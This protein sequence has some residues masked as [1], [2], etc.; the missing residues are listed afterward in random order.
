MTKSAFEAYL[1]YVIFDFNFDY[2]CIG[3]HH[4]Y[5]KASICG[6]YR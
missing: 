4:R 3:L 1:S 5:K 2:D 6:L